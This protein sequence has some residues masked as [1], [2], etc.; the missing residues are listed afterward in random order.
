MFFKL[1]MFSSSLNL[2]TKI[3]ILLTIFFNYGIFGCNHNGITYHNGDEWVIKG[4]KD[5]FKFI[6]KFV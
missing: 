2:I 3:F 5:F 1:K 4:K 6:F